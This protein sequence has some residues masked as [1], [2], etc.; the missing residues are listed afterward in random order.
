MPPHG[1][2]VWVGAMLL[3]SIQLVTRTNHG[4]FQQLSV[5]VH[6]ENYITMPDF[7]DLA[8]RTKLELRGCLRWV[9]GQ[10]PQLYYTVPM[11]RGSY[12]MNLIAMHE[13]WASWIRCWPKIKWRRCQGSARHFC[14]SASGTHLL[15]GIQRTA[16]CIRSITCILEHRKHGMLFRRAV[17]NALNSWP[18]NYFLPVTKSV[19]H[20]WNIKWHW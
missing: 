20:F 2:I 6:M 12:M 1:Y 4:C 18:E 3:S 10:C 15:L 9:L 11:Q 19:K 14:M 17:D 5:Q 8:I 13:I 16:I 7:A